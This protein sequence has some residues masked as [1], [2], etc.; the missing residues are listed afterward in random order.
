MKFHSTRGS[1][2]T[3]R[4][5]KIEDFEPH[6]VGHCQSVSLPVR[7]VD[8]GLPERVGEEA[9]MRV[10]FER[11]ILRVEEF[12]NWLTLPGF[13]SGLALGLT[14]GLSALHAQDDQGSSVQTLQQQINDL[15]KQVAGLQKK[16]NAPQ[17]LSSAR[18]QIDGG[19]NLFVTADFLYWTA[20]ENGLDYLFK[21]SL[22]A[23]GSL[24]SPVHGDVDSPHFEWDPG[25]RIGLGWNMGHDAWDLYFDWTRFHTNAKEKSHADNKVLYANFAD[26]LAAINPFEKASA[27][28]HV[29]VDWLDLELGK[30]FYATRYLTLRPHVGLRNAWVDQDFRFRYK[31]QIT[32]LGL[33][34][35]VKDKV[36]VKNDFWGLGIRTG[37]DTQWELG[38][39]FSILGDF[40]LAL[41][42]GDFDLHRRFKGPAIVTAGGGTFI[43]PLESH[44][45][46]DL[47]LAR[48]IADFD[49]GVQWDYMFAHDRF[50]VSLSAAW[51]QHM[52]FGQNQ[53]F[54]FY[55]TPSSSSTAHGK[56][57]S[58]NG[59][60]TLQ[61]LTISAR[62]DF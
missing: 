53:I 58:S 11:A 48:F 1:C 51:E 29:N 15:K 27:H 38:A 39:G 50:H 42:Y 36:R 60:L 46:K 12:C 19:C 23:F 2:K 5:W 21:T 25:F 35:G 40:A 7:R 18:P 10:G 44:Q 3:P 4:Q 45:D 32:P 28:T 6:C 22:V 16:K 61:G 55:D 52:F 57:V 49:L 9:R 54:N 14:L 8:G 24:T 56:L 26:T 30:A 20:Q 47:N 17:Y 33:S 13:T 37:L 43:V 41:L 34:A 59:D 31:N 62:F